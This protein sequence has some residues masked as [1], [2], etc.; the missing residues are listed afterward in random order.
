MKFNT[1]A[2]LMLAKPSVDTSKSDENAVN[3]DEASINFESAH[4]HGVTS[5]IKPLSDDNSR[6]IKP[7]INTESEQVSIFCYRLK[8]KILSNTC[9]VTETDGQCPVD[10]TSEVSFSAGSSQRTAS[11]SSSTCTTYHSFGA[12]EMMLPIHNAG[13][14]GV[15]PAPELKQVMN[16]PGATESINSVQTLQLP[17]LHYPYESQELEISYTGDDQAFACRTT[18]KVTCA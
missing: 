17:N 13:F 10:W 3:S 7:S 2:L 14:P 5:E 8:Y 16:I 11:A 15:N 9:E 4:S 6:V 1:E 18:Y 12:S